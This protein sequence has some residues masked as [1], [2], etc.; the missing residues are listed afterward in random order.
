MTPPRSASLNPL[1]VLLSL[2]AVAPSAALAQRAVIEISGANFRPMPLALALPLTADA[3]GRRLASEFDAALSY[4]LRACGLFQLLERK[5]FL[6]SPSEGVTAAAI[7]FKAWANVGADAVVKTQLAFDGTKLRG[8]LR[9][10]GVAAGREELKVSEAVAPADVRRLAHRLANALYKHYT[11][12]TGPFETKIAF[13]R[14]K[15]LGKDVYLADWDG[16]SAVPI[17]NVSLNV[18]PAILPDGSGVAFTSYRQGRPHLWVQRVGGQAQPLVS[19]G[20]MVSGVSFSPDGRRMAYSVAE[21]ESSELWVANVDGSSPRRLT[22]TKY[23]LNSSPS[24]S[25]DGRRLA[26]V[27]NRAGS[28]Q[29][30]VMN[31]A[32]GG[33]VKRLTFRGSYNTTP[34]WSPRGDVIAFTARDERNAFDIF[35][36]DVETGK[37]V[38]LTQD[39]GNNEEPAFSP[40][41]RLILFASTRAGGRHLY[42][43]TS[44]GNNQVALPLERGAYYTPDWS[45]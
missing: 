37:V 6:A 32:D 45:R 8:D 24:W 33:G 22:D 40:S 16:Q 17:T 4:D 15:G 2:L 7:D 38:R 11:S 21:G 34:A 10:F 39:A 36:V 41:G 13:V 35:T 26:F 5:S 23:F 9:L 3:D 28:P 12:E 25:P 27:S 31:S 43:M 20:A 42:V 1:A 44:D 29:V 19:S 14:K 18:L 30:Y